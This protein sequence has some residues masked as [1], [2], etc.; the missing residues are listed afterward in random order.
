MLSWHR[1]SDKSLGRKVFGRRRDLLVEASASEQPAEH[2]SSNDNPINNNDL[3]DNQ[4]HNAYNNNL[5]NH[6]MA[7]NTPTDD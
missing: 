1:P 4:K 6:N 5:N 2:S 3:D 7:N